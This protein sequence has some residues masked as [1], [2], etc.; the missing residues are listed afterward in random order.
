[1][2]LGLNNPF[3]CKATSETD[4]FPFWINNNEMNSN[5]Q[6]LG[7]INIVTRNKQKGESN[8]FNE[9]PHLAKFQKSIM[10]IIRC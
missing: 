6:D 1:M 8:M 3:T 4:Y 5:W 7:F 9:I 2:S 10:M